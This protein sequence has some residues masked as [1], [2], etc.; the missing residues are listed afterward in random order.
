MPLT[1][2]TNV[3]FV[4]NTIRGNYAAHAK[5]DG[6]R[7]DALII[8]ERINV[9]DIGTAIMQRLNDAYKGIRRMNGLTI[10]APNLARVGEEAVSKADGKTIEDAIRAFLAKRPRT[11]DYQIEIESN[12]WA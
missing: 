2:R 1:G 3:Y 10:D 5:R 9:E 8:E 7:G 11:P 4:R 6:T 12:A